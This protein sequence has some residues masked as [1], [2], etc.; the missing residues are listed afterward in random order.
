MA[1][2]ALRYA[3][4]MTASSFAASQATAEVTL[5]DDDRT[6][7][8][9]VDPGLY[10]EGVEYDAAR[11]RFLLGSIRRGEVVAVDRDG[12]PTVLVADDRLRSVVGIRA[13][14]TRGRLLVN[15][16]DYGVAERSGP[17]D[18]FETAALGV[19]D[20]E[21]GAPLQF[22]D[23]SALRPGE[24]NFI[25]DLAVDNDGNA[26]VT[27]SLAAA[28]YR[29]TPEGRGDVFI[30]HE[31][32]RGPGFNLNGIVVHP[33][34]YLL[35]A[36]KSDGSIFRVPLE[37]PASFEKVTIDTSLRAPDGLVLVDDRTL[38]AITNRAGDTVGNAFH[39]LRSENGWASAKSLGT[40]AA[41]DS[42]PTTGVIVDGRMVVTH[43]YLHTL[44]ATLEE[45]A[46]LQETFRLQDVGR[47]D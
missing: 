11:D 46:P 35:V 23:L 36:K 18:R 14:A 17:E 39:L 22:I 8:E 13:D 30:A 44:G 27:D 42:Y 31:A 33:D 43:G 38:L 29:V 19:Y 25:N 16:A 20:L 15:S 28:I 40:T 45:N 4:M 7:L 2:K 34:G 32:F 26:Y 6:F 1:L 21:T 9:I 12:T 3:V 5:H 24:S 47:L 41:S 10:P 37:D